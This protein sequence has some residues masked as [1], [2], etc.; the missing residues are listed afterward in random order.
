MKKFVPVALILLI[1]CAFKDEQNDILHKREFNISFDEV[2]EGVPV[3]KTVPDLWKFKSGKLFSNYIHDKYGFSWI[4]YRID[5]DTVYTDSTDTQV[6]MLVC[7]AA[8]TDEVNQTVEINFVTEEWDL[9]GY[10]RVTKNDKL[11]KYFDFVGREKG[12]KPKKKRAAM[13][14]KLIQIQKEGEK[15]DEQPLRPP[16][17]N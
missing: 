10:V 5:T 4:R 15:K 7:H 13:R 11:K 6:R 12:K 9:D 2:K 16:G 1:I 17:S 14:N 8:E 3:K